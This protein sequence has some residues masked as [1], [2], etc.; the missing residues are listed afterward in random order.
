M[1]GTFLGADWDSALDPGVDEEAQRQQRSDEIDLELQALARMRNGVMGPAPPNPLAYL[2]VFPPTPHFELDRKRYYILKSPQL[3]YVGA[4]AGR[5]GHYLVTTTDIVAR[6]GYARPIDVKLEIAAPNRRVPVNGPG[7]QAGDDRL[8]PD[9]R[10]CIAA[11]HY[12]EPAPPGSDPVYYEIGLQTLK[13]TLE[14]AE[15]LDLAFARRME[16]LGNVA[17]QVSRR[18]LLN[19]P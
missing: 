18:C 13:D 16:G 19:G 12:I 10:F 3:A 11:A 8:V 14:R 6:Q 17:P 7:M 2:Q 9:E 4:M 5:Y 1:Q 15:A